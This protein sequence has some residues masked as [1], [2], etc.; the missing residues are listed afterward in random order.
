VKDDIASDF[1]DVD[2][3]ADF[4]MFAS[5]L[6]LIESIPFF[7]ECKRE[8]CRR[9]APGA[10]TDVGCGSRRCRGAGGA[11]GDRGRSSASTAARR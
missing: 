9:A 8:L 10:N 7:A 6:D 1:K 4:A 2:R 5:C 11:G 3:A